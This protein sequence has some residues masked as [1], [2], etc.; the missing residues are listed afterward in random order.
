MK[1]LVINA[2]SSSLKFQLIDMNGEVVIAKGICERVGSPEGHFELKTEKGKYE[3][4]VAMA[5]HTEAFLVVKK[6]LTEGEYK[7]IDS[8]DEISAIGHRVVQG[9]SIYK[10]STLVTEDVIKGIE[11]LCDLAPLHNPAHIQGINACM[12]V[13]GK[14]VPEVAVF[15][16]AFHSTMPPEAYMFG[17][18]YEYYE[19]YQVRRYGFH[20][21]SHRYVSG[22]CARIMGKDLKDIKLI[23]CHL[24]NGSSITAIKDGKVIDTSMGLTPL[25]GFVMGTRSGGVDPSVVTF[26]QEKEG[27]TPAETSTILNKKSGIYGI[28]GGMSDDRDI[29]KAAAEGN[30]RAELAKKML[31]Y[32]IRK[33]IGSY[34]AAMQ[35][36]DAI[37]FTGGI[38]E[39][40]QPLR[41]N[42]CESFAY[43]G[44]TFN[45]EENSKAIRG[46]G[47][48]L[49]GP[50]SKV[51]VYVIPTNEELMIARDTKE[52]AEKII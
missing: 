1:I 41:Q 44:I 24:G 21:T 14:D 45:A 15:D 22:E 48:E 4:T 38:G 11:S 33:Y 34:I 19:K 46:V 37:V 35:G 13:F 40:S 9:G 29:L 43:L 52:I 47:G 8:L 6:H 7:V 25:D 30:E 49:S 36:V 51:K 28:S 23:T 31:W 17:V 12:E 20:G 50:D 2:G 18:P 32:Q 10:E 42:I 16:N 3:E 26:L 39:N 5:N 27:W